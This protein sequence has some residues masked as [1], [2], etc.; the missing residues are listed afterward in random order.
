MKN[1][2]LIL[3]ML[4]LAICSISSFSKIVFA[5]YTISPAAGTY[6]GSVNVVVSSLIPFLTGGLRASISGTDPG[7]DCDMTAPESFNSL[8]DF[9]CFGILPGYEYL[10][11]HWFG[12]S[13]NLGYY[14][15]KNGY[16]FKI[17]GIEAKTDIEA[18][19][20]HIDLAPRFHWQTRWTDLYGGPVIGLY[21]A[22]LKMNVEATFFD[23]QRDFNE[24]ESDSGLGFGLNLGFEFRIVKLFGIAIEDRIMSAVV[25]PFE[26]GGFNAGGNVFMIMGCFHL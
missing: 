1:W 19:V 17:E 6:K 13:S 5:E 11:R 7:P 14:G 10:F 24:N 18:S 8:A 16:D 3:K 15:G 22:R 26:G 23:W 20:W 12:L 21:Q 4:I 2:I 9:D 25:N